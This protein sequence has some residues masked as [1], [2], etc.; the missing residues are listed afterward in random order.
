MD[1]RAEGF[2]PSSFWWFQAVLCPCRVSPLPRRVL[3]GCRMAMPLHSE[4]MSLFP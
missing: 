2:S 3:S 1:R 4:L